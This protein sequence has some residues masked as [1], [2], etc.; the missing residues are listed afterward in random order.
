MGLYARRPD[1]HLY[2]RLMMNFNES[3]VFLGRRSD[4]NTLFDFS[5]RENLER[6][7][8]I[9]GKKADNVFR[10]LA[11]HCYPGNRSDEEVYLKLMLRCMLECKGKFDFIEREAAQ[12]VVELYQ[13]YFP[14]VVVERT[15]RQKYC[16]QID[17]QVNEKM[18]RY[19]N[20]VVNEHGLVDIEALP[21]DELA[22]MLI[23]FRNEQR[24]SGLV[25]VLKEG[26]PAT[27]VG[28]GQDPVPE[29]AAAGV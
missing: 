5:F 1:N 13:R 18:L 14:G 12:D 20:Q 27:K 22:D 29:E 15:K 28:I 9:H 3:L 26:D 10:V 8:R 11:Q 25:R 23:R 19:L 7:V 24:T 4:G 17:L 2:Q 16:Y 6:R 21:L